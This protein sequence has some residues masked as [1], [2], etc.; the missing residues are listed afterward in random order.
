MKE[1]DPEPM[2]RAVAFCQSIAVS[3]KITST[4]NAAS[5]T[6]INELPGELRETTQLINSR[7]IDGTMNATDRNELLA[8]LKDEPK[9]RECRVLTN[10]RCLSEGVDVPSLDAVFIPFSAKLTGRCGTVRWA[11]LCANLPAK[12]TA[13]SLSLS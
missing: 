5:E 8:W 3:K 2:R 10:V 11:G 7:H 12:N 13:I 9:E 4:F 6:Y 1:S